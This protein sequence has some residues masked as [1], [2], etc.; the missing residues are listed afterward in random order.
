MTSDGARAS[1]YATAGATPIPL[2]L[3]YGLFTLFFARKCEWSDTQIHSTAALHT[4][5]RLTVE[6]WHPQLQIDTKN[7]INLQLG[8]V[9]IN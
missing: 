5:D 4:P 6:A 3:K 1:G 8:T 2:K 9:C 7:R